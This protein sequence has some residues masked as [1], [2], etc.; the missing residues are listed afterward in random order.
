VDPRLRIATQRVHVIESLGDRT[1]AE[2]HDPVG[3]ADRDHLGI[4]GATEAFAC[5]DRRARENAQSAGAVAE[6]IEWTS[7]T[8]ARVV[9]RIRVDEIALFRLAEM[10][11]LGAMVGIET[12]VEMGDPRALAGARIGKAGE[13]GVE[14]PVLGIAEP[15]IVRRNGGEIILVLLVRLALP[16][17]KSSGARRAGY[18]C[19]SLHE[20]RL[21]EFHAAAG[22]T[23]PIR[24][25]RVAGI[26]RICRVDARVSGD[27]KPLG[28]T[29][30]RAEPAGCADA[31][32]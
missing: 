3:N 21:G 6:I 17:R 14:L 29:S 22:D 23:L 19:P 31:A 7:G 24:H 26:P 4:R 10:D 12:G 18:D 2:Q 9:G 32:E 30:R 28:P 25:Q 20:V 5:A 15:E 8:V 1:I 13:R 27:A 11:R 16:H